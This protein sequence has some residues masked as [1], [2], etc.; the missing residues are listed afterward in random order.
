MLEHHIQ[1]AIVYRLA[2]TPSLTFS[3]LK[4]ETIENKLFTYHLKKVVAA[5]L[6]EKNSSGEYALTSQGRL[7]G[8]HV[9]ERTEAMADRAYS[10]LFLVIR[11]TQDRAWLLYRRGSHPLYGKVGFMHATPNAHETSLE[12]AARV[13]KERTGLSA[14]FTALGSGFFRVFEGE[15]L[16]SFTNFTLL[17]C[18]HATGEL[19]GNDELADYF[20]TT[21]LNHNN[22]ELLPNMPTLIELYEVGTPFFVEKMLKSTR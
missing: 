8:V 19:S 22:Q 16:E 6:V 11:R 14:E 13:C 7:L 4:P 10:V 1:R 15:N 5:G 17:V 20:W 21:E 2:L 3:A 9:L 18:E 12:T